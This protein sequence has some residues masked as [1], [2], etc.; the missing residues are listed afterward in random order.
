M[1]AKFI[2]PQAG[3][4]GDNSLP[5]LNTLRSACTGST[6][7]LFCTLTQKDIAILQAVLPELGA[8]M[9]PPEGEEE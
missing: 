3:F 6:I 8:Q 9:M 7:S 1:M 2:A 4:S 5:C